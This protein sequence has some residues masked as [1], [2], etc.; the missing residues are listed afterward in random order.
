[1]TNADFV[2]A[3]YITSYFEGNYKIKRKIGLAVKSQ[4]I[5]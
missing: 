4:D 5:F 1:M 2:L 3:D